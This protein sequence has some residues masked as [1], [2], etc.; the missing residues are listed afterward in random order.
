MA[1]YKN[2]YK[3]AKFK[4]PKLHKLKL[5][6]TDRIILYLYQADVDNGRSDEEIVNWYDGLKTALFMFSSSLIH[7]ADLTFFNVLYWEDLRE[8]T[9]EIQSEDEVQP[10]FFEGFASIP[11]GHKMSFRLALRKLLNEELI[12][13]FVPSMR[14]INLIGGKKVPVLNLFNPQNRDKYKDIVTISLTEKG[15]IEGM[16]LSKKYLGHM[17]HWEV[18]KYLMYNKE[19]AELLAG[20]KRG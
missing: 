14:A 3:T 2:R 11:T 6:M 20:P 9:S 19:F 17:M 10:G 8:Y 16:K 7:S 15:F 18:H 13:G 1:M 12:L 5:S 4:E